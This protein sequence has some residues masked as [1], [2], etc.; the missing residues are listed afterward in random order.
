MTKRALMLALAGLLI[1][2]PVLAVPQAK[3]P[4]KPAPAKP[5][6]AK[7]PASAATPTPGAGPI[8]VVETVKGTFTVSKIGRAH[9]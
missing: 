8:V 3:P 1:A 2:I 4:A 6:G 7:A 9:V 5:A